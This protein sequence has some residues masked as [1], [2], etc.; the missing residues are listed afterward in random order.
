MISETDRYH[1]LAL[2]RI[3]VDAR[4]PIT[5]GK[6]DALGRLNSYSING[7]AAVHIKHSSKRL[8]PW[9]FSFTISHLR[10]LADLS[11]QYAMVWILCVC[12]PDGLVAIS[13]TEFA[14]ITASRPGGVASLRIDRDKRAMYRVYGNDAQL[15][16]AKPNGVIQ[17]L[18]S[19]IPLCGGE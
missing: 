8:T 1:G 9:N 3:I 4:S 5:V 17:L 7:V 12:G 15:Q 18:D 16:F 13:L 19:L 11:Q 14:G 10:E 6:C 2:R